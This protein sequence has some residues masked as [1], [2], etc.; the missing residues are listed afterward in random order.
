ME[1]GELAVIKVNVHRL[2]GAKKWKILR[3]ITRVKEFPQYMP[4][5]KQCSTIEKGKKYAITS[6]NVDVDGIPL[7]WKE[8]DEFDF[9]HFTISFKAIEGDLERFDG[10]WQLKDHPSGGTEVFI[11][12][13]AKIGIP[14]LE[15]VIGGVIAEK[16]RK[17][18]DMMLSA[19]DEKLTT[20]RYKNIADRRVSDIRGFAVIGHPYNLNHLIRYF[21]Y[22]KPE[23]KLPSEGFLLKLFEMTP[24]YRSYDIKNFKSITGKTTNGY[25]IMCPIIPDMLAIKPEKVVEKVGQACRVAEELGVGIVSLGGFTSIA[26]E[27]YGKILTGFANVPLTTGNTLTVA[28]VLEGVYQACKLMEIDLAKAKVT[29]I[30]GAGDIGGSCA[31]ILASKVEE[32]TITGRSEKNLMEAERILGYSG[33]ARIKTSRDNNQAVRNADVLIAAASVSSSIIDFGNF[34]PGAVICDVG[35]PKNISYTMCHRDD[36]FIFSGGLVKLPTEFDLGFDIGLPSNRILYGCFAEAI[37][38]DLEERYE[39]FSWGKGAITAD[40]VAL[41]LEMCKKHGFELAPFFWGIRQ[42]GD[43]AIE[44]IKKNARSGNRAPIVKDAQ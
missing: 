3:L 2:L 15:K 4:N 28:M 18:F 17:N 29:I 30:G 37:V 20:Q 6:W 5:V 36:I 11:Q 10:E 34:K 13:I 21:K 19:I 16:L 27:K 42:I 44:K 8:R 43:Q 40:R 31:K 35:Y 7:Q 38:L 33:K 23:L 25:F 12:V 39:N 24:S 1:D 22:F 41:I 26:G 32:I 14:L 9:E